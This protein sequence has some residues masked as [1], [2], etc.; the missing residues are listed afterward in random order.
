M[1]Q[2]IL[3]VFVLSHAHAPVC[4]N[5]FPSSEALTSITSGFLMTSRGQRKGALGTNELTHFV[6]MFSLISMRSG[7][8]SINFYFP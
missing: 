6:S 8:L 7:I 4:F 5:T 1:L 3:N 2:K